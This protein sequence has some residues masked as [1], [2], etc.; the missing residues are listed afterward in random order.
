MSII[1]TCGGHVGKGVLCAPFFFLLFFGATEN[2]AVLTPWTEANNG[3]RESDAWKKLLDRGAMTMTHSSEA[4]NVN[5]KPGSVLFLPDFMHDMLSMPLNSSRILCIFSCRF[6][7][8]LPLMHFFDPLAQFFQLVF[9]SFRSVSPF[10]NESSDL[11]VSFPHS[12]IF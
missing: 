8:F 3:P 7:L 11:I 10:L 5:Q 6:A 9:V 2:G 4:A 12:F 1:I